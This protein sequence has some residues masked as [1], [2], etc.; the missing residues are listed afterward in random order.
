LRHQ[1]TAPAASCCCASSPGS[2]RWRAERPPEAD[3][4]TGTGTGTKRCAPAHPLGAKRPRRFEAPASLALAP[5]LQLDDVPF[6]IGH[7]DEGQAARPRDF[8]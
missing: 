7:V 3:S 6:G 4:G 2:R 8:R 5:T 1:P